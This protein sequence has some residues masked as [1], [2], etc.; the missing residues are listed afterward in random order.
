[1]TEATESVMDGETEVEDNG[2]S[3]SLSSW[4]SDSETEYGPEPSEAGDE[5]D[6]AYANNKRR[7]LMGDEDYCITTSQAELK[8][9]ARS[10]VNLIILD[11][12]DT[13]LPSTWLQQQGL[14]IASDADMPNHE[15]K[16]ELS[17]VARHVIKTLRRAR[18]LGHVIIVTN[19][20][21]G[22]VELTCAKFL[23]EV[24]PHLEGIK[25]TSARS[26]FEHIQPPSPVQW[27]WLTFHREIA[28]FYRMQAKLPGMQHKISI[29]SIGDA[30]HERTALFRA[31]EDRDC[32]T[33]SLKLMERPT[34]EQLL[35]QH[36]L[37]FACLRPAV[38]FNGNLDLCLQV[39]N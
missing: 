8:M 34:V 1:M 38:N 10:E 30:N 21:K 36:E 20:E 16:M 29:I 19:A 5:M 35:R 22:W 26:A 25:V 18:R 39:P 31:T 17:M 24:F 7:K 14:Q 3:S 11:W 4:D 23:P 15:Q 12:D 2:S 6:T 9:Q 33:K 32:W 27:K 37:L 13:L 28:A